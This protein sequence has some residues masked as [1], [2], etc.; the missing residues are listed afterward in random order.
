MKRSSKIA[1]AT[2]A[3]AGLRLAVAALT[4]PGMGPGTRSARAA[5]MHEA[6]SAPRMER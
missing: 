2:A 4:H 3:A 5:A 1:L 6:A